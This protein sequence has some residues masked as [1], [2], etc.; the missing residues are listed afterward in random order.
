MNNSNWSW[1]PGLDKFM[2][3]VTSIKLRINNNAKQYATIGNK[4]K[5]PRKS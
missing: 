4:S 2:K 3:K 1:A 5:E